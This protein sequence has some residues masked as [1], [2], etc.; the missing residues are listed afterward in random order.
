VLVTLG[1]FCLHQL[2]L[3]RP[4]TVT[5]GDLPQNEFHTNGRQPLRILRKE[6]DFAKITPHSCRD[7]QPLFHGV[8]AKICTKSPTDMISGAIAK[9]GAWDIELVHLAMKARGLE[10]YTFFFNFNRNQTEN[11][12]YLQK[13]NFLLFAKCLKMYSF[14]RICI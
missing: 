12:R 13:N 6:E 5:E 2:L 8:V 9:T 1:L 7:T 11:D 14:F 4:T 10:F 3:L